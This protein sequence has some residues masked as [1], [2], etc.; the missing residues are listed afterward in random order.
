MDK[1]ELAVGVIVIVGSVSGIAAYD[2]FPNAGIIGAL[3]ALFA[4]AWLLYQF[5]APMNIWNFLGLLIN[6]PI[7]ALIAFFSVF[8][9]LSVFQDMNL[10]ISVFG[11]FAAAVLGFTGGAFLFKYWNM[12][13]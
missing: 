13:P 2:A 11:S 8:V 9:Y 1:D 10:S 3:I 5:R 4:V 7:A 12:G 6:P